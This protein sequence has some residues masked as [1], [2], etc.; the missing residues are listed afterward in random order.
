MNKLYTKKI[1]LR[2]HV[3]DTITIAHRTLLKTKHNPEKLFDVTVMPIIFMIMFSFLFGGAIAGSVSA[4]L[5]IIVPGIL[6][7]TLISSSATAG[8]QIREDIETGVFD[9]FNSLPISRVSIL[10]GILVADLLRYII[11]ATIS[12][13]TGFLIGWRPGLGLGYVLIATIFVILVCW[14]ISWIF[15][16]LGLLFKSTA[17]IQGFSMMTTFI[18][19]FISSA[20]VP[21]ETLPDWLET[22][23]RVNPVT[24][25]IEAFKAIAYTGTFGS[26]V[27]L[28][29]LGSIIILIIFVPLTLR[30]YKKQ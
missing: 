26:D 6:I 8:T 11:A 13:V 5:P 28:A 2:S 25:L 15:A 29:I 30:L 17:T 27:Y 16:C 7:E 9:R 4:Y 24:H 21:I 10:T 12:L 22:I 23:A 1:N 3:R 19:T 14:A 20:F 18:L